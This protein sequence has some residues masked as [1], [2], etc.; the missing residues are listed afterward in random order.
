MPVLS[1]VIFLLVLG[2]TE[3]AETCS[4]P[5]SSLQAI[6]ALPGLPGNDGTPG[7]PGPQGVQG[8][9]G[10]AGPIGPPGA[11]SNTVIEQI[12]RDILEQLRREL[13]LTC[14]GDS[15]NNPATSCNAIYECNSTASSGNY[16]L[17][18]ATGA[19]QTFCSAGKQ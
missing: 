16:W 4:G 7:A 19:V 2:F 12:T 17:K 3:S 8:P 1:A 10:L 15:E 18:T 14:S 11:V 13:N 9:Q 5:R 6:Q